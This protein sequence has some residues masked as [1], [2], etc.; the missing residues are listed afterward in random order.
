M[1]IRYLG[2]AAAEG[3]PA[4]FCQCEACRKA[5]SLGGKNIRTRAQAVIDE[6]ILM[7]FGPDTYLHM[8]QQ[9]LD[10]PSIQTVLITH[11]HQDHCYPHELL[12]RG[13]PYAHGDLGVLTVY[14][15]A[16][17][18]AKYDEAAGQNDSS[19]FEQVVRFEEVHEFMPFETAEGYLVT[20]LL[21]RH[22]PQEKCL[23]YLVEK[24]GKTIFY[25]HDSG[26]Y[27]EETWEYLT[28]KK[29]DLV[30]F[31]CTNVLHPDG[32]YHMGIPAALQ[33]RERFISIGI[34]SEQTQ[35]V[36]SHFSHNGILMHDEIKAVGDRENLLTAWD[37]FYVDI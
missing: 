25:G 17:V 36:I 23:I 26:I 8:L 7:D 6:K 21:A 11:S 13:E 34:C 27:P 35:Y 3:W 24:D 10:L 14:G 32:N 33:A 1:R 37:G 18:K 28:G 30:S 16:E 15:C 9:G 20:P 4:L 31:D 12:L 22:N 5:A 19:N 29:I 2:T